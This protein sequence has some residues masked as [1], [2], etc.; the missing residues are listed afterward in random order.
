MRLAAPT[1]LL[2]LQDFS[3][4]VKESKLFPPAW[5]V[6][7]FR[8]FLPCSCQAHLRFISSLKP[9]HHLATQPLSLLFLRPRSRARCFQAQEL[10]EKERV[11]I[12]RGVSLLRRVGM[13]MAKVRRR[14]TILLYFRVGSPVRLLPF[15]AWL[16]NLDPLSALSCAAR[17]QQPSVACPDLEGWCLNLDVPGSSAS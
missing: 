17:A 13:C 5:F 12:S 1:A 11:R 15:P 9:Q 8:P 3:R 14:S 6:M 7:P 10:W 4:I 2:L 16:T